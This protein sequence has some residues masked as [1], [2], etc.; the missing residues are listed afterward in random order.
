MRHTKVAAAFLVASVAAIGLTACSNNTGGGAGKTTLTWAALTSEKPAVDAIVKA[1]EKAN[2]DITVKTTLA[3]TDNYQTTLRTQL[4]AGTAPDVFFVW[5][6]DGNPMAMKVVQK[7]GMIADLS[8]QSFASKIPA[9]FKPLTTVGGKTY[10]APV[11]FTGIG[12]EYNETAMKAA[13]LTAPTTWTGLLTFCADAKA[14]GKA[15]F[16][17]AAATPWNTQL[18]PYALTPTLVYG[19]NPAFPQQMTAG[20]VTFANSMWKEAFDK[21]SEMQKKGCFQPSDLGTVYADALN[22]V[23][24]GEALASVQVTASVAMMQQGAPSGT[25]FKLEPLPATD[26]ASQTRMAGAAGASYGVN[27]KTKNMA[28]A[29]KLVDYLASPEGT[30]IYAT[31]ASGLPAIPNAAFKLDP[32]LDVVPQYLKGGKTDP[33]MDQLWPNAKVQ[34]TMFVVLQKVL[35]GKESA[36]DALKEMDAA[37]AEGAK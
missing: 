2:P 30:N 20:K 37:F 24:K 14:K 33:F 3:D 36:T 25:T 13:G 18:I 27:A 31:A 5:P 19:P 32:S 15:A 11:T 29:L 23:A 35:A 4:S 26:N 34:Q 21:Y 9:A 10:I 12:A 6:G 8:K 7:A 17:L 22:M 28:A 16:A 1:F